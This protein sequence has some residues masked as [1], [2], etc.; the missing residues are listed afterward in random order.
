MSVREIYYRESMDHDIN[1]MAKI[2]SVEWGTKEYWQQRIA[3]YL[4]KEL[5]P[6]HALLS[7]ACYVALEHDTVIGFIAGHLS[8]RYNCDGELQ[9]INVMKEQRGTGVGLELIRLLAKWFIENK[10]QKICVDP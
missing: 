1:D 5:H 7:R 2:R 4:N 10:A 6:Q 3:A 9:W 8:K